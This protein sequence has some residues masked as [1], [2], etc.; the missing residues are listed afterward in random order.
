M[1]VHKYSITVHNKT[2]KDQQYGLFNKKPQIDA[3]VSPTKV[4]SGVLQSATAF[5]GATTTF[6]IDEHIN[7]IAATSQGRPADSIYMSVHGALP[8][9]L[10][11][12][13]RN[14]AEHPGTSFNIEARGDFPVFAMQKSPNAAP[15]D[16][17]QIN[18]GSDFSKQTAQNCMRNSK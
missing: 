9:L 13:A 6:E 3:A 11:A 7:A 14:G 16:A 18:T 15:T 10:G 8:A 4:W 5:D 1:P 17:L 12:A 2:K